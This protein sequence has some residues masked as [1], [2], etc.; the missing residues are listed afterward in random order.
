VVNSRGAAPYTITIAYLIFVAVY[1]G[2]FGPMIAFAENS[3]YNGT[4]A[5][6]SAASINATDFNDYDSGG[7]VEYIFDVVGFATSGKYVLLNIILFVP[8]GAVIVLG[9][10]KP[11]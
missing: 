9:W 6:F 3:D 8:V 4:E 5:N 11:F 10:I 7:L 2:I 1:F